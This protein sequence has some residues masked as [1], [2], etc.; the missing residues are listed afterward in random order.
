[1]RACRT[2]VPLMEFICTSNVV[3]ACRSESA[4]G[5]EPDRLLLTS[6]TRV[7]RPHGL[8]R[9]P[10]HEQCAGAEPAPADGCA[11]S[12]PVAV[13]HWGP[14]VLLNSAVSAASSRCCAGS[15][16]GPLQFAASASATAGRQRRLRAVGS[17]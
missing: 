3:M 11:E 8:Q 1:V 10:N 2:N 12:Q 15:S 4:A 7:T 6:A 9:T 13:R 17:V 16:T 14:P 5:S